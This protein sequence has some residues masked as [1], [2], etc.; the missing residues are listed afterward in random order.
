MSLVHVASSSTNDEI[1]LPQ[2]QII[3]VRNIAKGSSLF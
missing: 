1:F 2:A 3:A